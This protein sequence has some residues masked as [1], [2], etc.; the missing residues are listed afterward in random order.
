MTSRASV[1]GKHLNNLIT[2]GGVMDAESKDNKAKTAEN[3]AKTAQ[4]PAQ[5][6]AANGA[7]QAK[8]T[9]KPAAKTASNAGKQAAKP[10][11]T[12]K[13]YGN[14]GSAARKPAVKPAVKTE[15]PVNFYVPRHDA[16]VSDKINPC[17][18]DHY[19][20]LN[21]VQTVMEFFASHCQ[22]CSG[23]RIFFLFVA[24]LMSVSGVG[25]LQALSAIPAALVALVIIVSLLAKPEELE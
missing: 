13:N 23:T 3:K 1:M 6:A 19:D 18:A 2:S 16:P 7:K 22:C 17:H 5:K 8:T 4:K 12:S 10:A 24:Y 21:P 14:R 9:G 20:L 15:T 25:L 11:K